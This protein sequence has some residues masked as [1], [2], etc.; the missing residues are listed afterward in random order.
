MNR[1]TSTTATEEYR[2]I[3]WKLPKR[4]GYTTITSSTCCRKNVETRRLREHQ[5]E[6]VER[7]KEEFQEML[8]EH[9]ELFYDLDLNATP[10]CDKMTE[11]HSVLNEE[12]RYRALQ[13]LAP[14]RESLLLKHIGFVYHPTKETCLSGPNCVDLKVEQVLANRLV[15]L[16]HGRSNLY[17]SNPSVDK[18]NL[19]LLGKEG[20]AQELQ[21][22]SGSVDRR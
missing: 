11:I 10:S 17:Y 2:S 8:F 9:A 22:K 5:Q 21:M 19:C 15:Q 6:I 4:N 14:D 1:T 7:A 3:C 16:D 12:P 18:L 20:L 13:K